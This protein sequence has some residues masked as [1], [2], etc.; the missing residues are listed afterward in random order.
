MPRTHKIPLPGR[1]GA[2][3]TFVLACPPHLDMPCLVHSVSGLCL[4]LLI[5]RK[6]LALALLVEVQLKKTEPTIHSEQ[7]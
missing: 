3:T 7:A 2:A 4:L 1:A 6:R 5:Y